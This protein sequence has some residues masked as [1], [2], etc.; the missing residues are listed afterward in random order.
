M[1]LR[2][3][4]PVLL[5]A[6]TACSEP[7]V[8]PSTQHESFTLTQLKEHKVAVWPLAVADLDESTTKTVGQD[9]GGRDRFMDHFSTQFSGRL[10]NL[11]PQGSVEVARIMETFSSQAE[12]LDPGQL[13]GNQDPNNRFA[14]KE[15]STVFA[16]LATSPVLKDIRFL[17]IPRDLSIGRQW[18]HTA[19]GGGVFHAGPGGSGTFVGGGS[20]SAKTSARLRLAV[21]DLET[22]KVVWDGSVFAGASSTF[23]KSTAL[24]EV[25]EELAG[26]F[27]K[28]VLGTR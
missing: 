1:R 10:L 24:Q 27:I 17:V 3:L 9:H 26:N 20:S 13:L 23:M 28:A 11:V 6:L 5:L 18:T 8:I 16:T 12:L 14:T 21:V 2:F 25:E 22:R 4:A 7:K 15:T 19:G